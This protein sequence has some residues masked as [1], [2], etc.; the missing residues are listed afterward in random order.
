MG[1][2]RHRTFSNLNSKVKLR[3]AV[4]FICDRKKGGC[5]YPDELA[6]DFT[7]TISKTVPSVLEGKHPSKT[8]PSCATLETYEEMPILIL[9]NSK[10][11]AIE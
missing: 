10:G 3:K 7:G 1:E 8:I 11:E 5:L 6:E 2:K 9:I 4:L